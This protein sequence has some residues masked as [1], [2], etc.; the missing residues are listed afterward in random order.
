MIVDLLRNDLG[1]NC[2]PG[3]IHVPELFTVEAYPTVFH[4]VSS[5]EGT[6]ADDK[7]AVDVLRDCFPGGSIT[8]APKKR[9]ME[10][11]RELEKHQ[12][13]VYCGAIGYISFNGNM[14]TNVAIRTMTV[15]QERL[16]FWAGGGIV[17]DSEGNEEFQETQDKARAFFRLLA[18]KDE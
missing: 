15:S 12:R 2:Q 18:V 9:A 1:K 13:G 7:T 14:D 8:G 11:I 3:S 10:I 16:S 6:I 17:A 4:L 5:I